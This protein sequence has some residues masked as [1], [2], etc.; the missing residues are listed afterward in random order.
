MREIK[1]DIFHK[2]I[3]DSFDENEKYFACKIYI[4]SADI[5]NAVGLLKELVKDNDLLKIQ[6]NFNTDPC[7]IDVTAMDESKVKATIQYIKS[8]TIFVERV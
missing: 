6:I 5:D 8:N 4:Y 7:I 2:M 1:N 3:A